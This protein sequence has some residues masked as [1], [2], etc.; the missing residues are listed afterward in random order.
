MPEGMNNQGE[1]TASSSSLSSKYVQFGCGLSAPSEWLNFDASP[2]LRL[3]KLPVIGRFVP[4]GPFGRF[5]SNVQYGNIVSGLPIPDSYAELLYCS[6]VLEH[7]SLNELQYSLQNCWRHLQ[8]GGIFRMV[9]PD[10]EV[11][12]HEYVESSSPDAAI[13][14]MRNSI[15]GSEIRVRSLFSFVREWLGGSRH[16]WMWDYLSLSSELQRV[17]FVNIRR[18]N[19]G[20]SGVNAFQSVEEP[21]R[22][23]RALG[24]QCMKQLG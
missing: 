11:L 9:L 13:L 10:L 8:P 24:I 12:A 5:P 18:A 14:F 1:K 4:D 2:T 17:G 21:G 3:Q 20:D 19:F 15:L 6:H 7:L 16:L 23:E 22:W